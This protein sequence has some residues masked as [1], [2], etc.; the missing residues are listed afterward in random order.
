MKA[1]KNPYKDLN[2]SFNTCLRTAFHKTRM[3]A[4]GSRNDSWRKSSM[5]F[6]I[7]F[8]ALLGLFF[9][10]TLDSY[11][12]AQ[13]QNALKQVTAKRDHLLSL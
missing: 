6:R 7:S 2:W 8:L 11:Y 13:R 10:L 9:V 3:A 12:V 5:I 1:A 4:T